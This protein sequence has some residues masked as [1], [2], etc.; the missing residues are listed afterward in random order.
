M[1]HM[2]TRSS[3]H[4]H[5]S[6]VSACQEPRELR[7]DAHMRQHMRRE[8]ALMHTGDKRASP[9]AHTEESTAAQPSCACVPH[10]HACDMGMRALVHHTPEKGQGKSR[11]MEIRS[12]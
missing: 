11:A 5:Q 3:T 9:F 8:S 1:A 4:Q 2:H 7:V 6:I 12:P 10:G